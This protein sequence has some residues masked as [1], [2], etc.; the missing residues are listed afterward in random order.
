LGSA[1][2]KIEAALIVLRDINPG[3]EYAKSFSRSSGGKAAI[4]PKISSAV[5]YATGSSPARSGSSVRKPFDQGQN[6]RKRLAGGA[7]SFQLNI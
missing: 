4:S 3:V 5:V 6:I 7:V 1:F 2:P